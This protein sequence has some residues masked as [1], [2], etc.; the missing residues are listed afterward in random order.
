MVRLVINKIKRKIRKVIS[1]IKFLKWIDAFLRL[2]KI[3]RKFD[4]YSNNDIIEDNNENA[5][6]IDVINLNATDICNS[7]CTMCNIWKQKKEFEFSAEELCEILKDP[8][9]NNL[10]H[11]GVTGGEPTL[12]K[13]LPQLFEAIIKAQPNIHGLSTI[14]NCIREKNVIERI[15]A[16]I[17]ICKKYNKGFSMMVSLDG[18]GEVHD[19]VRGTKGNFESALRVINYYKNKGV[20]IATGT[21]ISKVNVW[22]VD[23]MLVFL[24]ENQIYGRFRVAEFIKRLYNDNRNE[25]IR[26]F[27]K[28]ET[29]HLILF[30]YKLILTYEKD[31][32][33]QNTYYSIINILSGGERLIGCPYHSNGVVLNSKGELAYCAPKSKIIGNAIQ[34]KAQKIYAENLSELSYIK[35][36]HCSSCIHDY[37][38]QITQNEVKNRNIKSYW[39]EYLKI[40]SIIPFSKHEKVKAQKISE[41]MQIFITGWYGTETVG[42]KAILAQIIAELKLEFGTKTDIIVTSLFPHITQRTIEELDLQVT[43]IDAYSES[44]VAYA[45]GSELVIMG[46]GPL[47]DLDELALPLIAFK[48]AKTSGH[49]N[50]V[51]GCGL[52]PLFIDRNIRVVKKILYLA[53]EIKLRDNES[54]RL[55]NK[56]LNSSKNVVMTGD[57]AKRFV[58]QYQ[59]QKTQ[60]Q[61]PI[62][63]CFLRELTY[64]YFRDK[65]YDVF[66]EMK[67]NFEKG[68]AEF[69]LNKAKEINA[70]EIRFDHMHNFVVGNDDRDFSRYFIKNYFQSSEVKVSY[71]N[72]LSTVDSIVESMQQSQHNIC[73]RFHSVLFAE[74]LQTSFSAIDYTS[75]G[76]IFNY[77][78]DC[79]KLGCLLTVDGISKL[80][81]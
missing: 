46:G 11:V 61:K 2:K 69:I 29:Y 77:L 62:L 22:G 55:A 53:D 63:S 73:M 57:P 71:N 79:D 41:N 76:K 45:K 64:E 5:Y 38:A 10:K 65:N 12:R 27:D 74:T 18:V 3:Q 33:F 39:K 72:R 9:F 42:D 28:D 58:D 47:M 68:L 36:N 31:P 20:S 25:V 66:L 67:Q 51:Y 1:Q 43:V 44:F 32:T 19:K 60:K 80:G 8:L 13:D 59:K 16:S 75:G 37:H 6:S 78:S 26:N 56:L 4:Y 21:T 40:D 70:E 35:N 7:G 17:E 14:T 54:V 50:V 52:G 24:R 23:D 30:F 49:R 15:D 48:L 81:K 34:Q